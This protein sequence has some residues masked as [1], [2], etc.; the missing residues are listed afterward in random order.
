MSTLQ[1]DLYKQMIV[2]ARAYVD[3]QNCK[4]LLTFSFSFPPFVKRYSNGVQRGCNEGILKDFRNL[5]ALSG[6]V[7]IKNASD[8]NGSDSPGNAGSPSILWVSVFLSSSQLCPGL[9][10]QIFAHCVQCTQ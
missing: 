10:C 8:A 3:W 4:P 9:K 1:Q 5:S 7:T 2:S 6:A